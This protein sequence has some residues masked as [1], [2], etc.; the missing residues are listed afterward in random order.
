MHKITLLLLTIISCALSNVAAQESS[1]KEL[2]DRIR[3]LAQP[4]VDAEVINCVAIGVIDGDTK[5]ALSAGQFSK[6]DPTKA[7]QNTIFEIGS[8][9]KV[10]TGVLLADAIERG[11]VTADQPAGDLLPDGV[12]MPVFEDKPERKITLKHLSTHVSGL[13]RMPGNFDLSDHEDPYANYSSKEMFEFLNS[14]KLS[15]QPGGVDEYSNF[16]VSVL[17]QLLSQKQETN[18]ANLLETRIAKPLGMS[19]TSL[20]PNADQVKRLAPPHDGSL[21]PAK[22]WYF[23]AMAGAGAIRSTIGDML[24]FAQANLDP[25]DSEIG[26]AIDLAF[27]QQRTSRGYNSTPVG[28]GWV[29]NTSTQTRWHNGQTGGY[30]S[31]MFVNRKSNRAVVVLSNTATGE[32]DKLGAEIMALLKGDDVKPREFRQSVEVNEEVCKKYVGKY[33]LNEALTFD[34]AYA[35]DTKTG[36]TVQLTGQPAF[37]I[38]PKSNSRWF[39]KIVKAE[40]EFTVDDQGKCVSLT[41]HQNGIQQTAKKQ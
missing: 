6:T 1:S 33:K 15:R 35:A 34:V 39:L 28:F 7:D 23:D 9:S 30:H 24:K 10:F 5:L 38:Y 22:S 21:S 17:G 20:K 13:P 14:H 25:P 3:S 32:V 2:E 11:I 18:Y 8:I 4:Y 41:L 27:R 37:K 16:A 19:N 40:I 12:N 36:L 31:I 26:K 29:I